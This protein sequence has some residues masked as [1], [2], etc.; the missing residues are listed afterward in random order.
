MPGP[1]VMT[2]QRA[3]TSTQ[4]PAGTEAHSTMETMARTKPV[5]SGHPSAK[6][7]VL[8]GGPW[9]LRTPTRRLRK[10]PTG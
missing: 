4:L 9:S 2:Q 6:F 3:P 5:R 7:L 1:P 8:P 10:D